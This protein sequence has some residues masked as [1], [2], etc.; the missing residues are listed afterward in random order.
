MDPGAVIPS[1]YQLDGP[2]TSKHAFIGRSEAMQRVFSWL[3]GS[4]GNALVIEGQRHVGKTSLLHEVRR[5]WGA[6]DRAVQFSLEQY[7]VAPDLTAVLHDLGREIMRATPQMPYGI[8]SRRSSPEHV[9]RQLID[10]LNM[11]GKRRTTRQPLVVMLDGLSIPGVGRPSTPAA[12]SVRYFA[13]IM[14]QCP[15]TRFVVTLARDPDPAQMAAP[16]LRQAQRMKI[17]YFSRAEVAEVCRLSERT[18]LA[19]R[20]EW[21]DDAVDALVVMTD[22][23]PWLTQAICAGVW[24]QRKL[25]GAWHAV[26]HHDLEGLEGP[27]QIPAPAG[28]ALR[29]L[30]T[31]LG[32][33]ARAVVWLVAHEGCGATVDELQAVIR[34]RPRGQSDLRQAYKALCDLGLLAAAGAGVR[35]APALLGVWVSQQQASPPDDPAR[36]TAAA[37]EPFKPRRR[38]LTLGGAG[39]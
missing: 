36:L 3:D 27:D 39:A 17:G 32:S 10:L 23:H 13:M 16:V 34:R 11:I 18:G 20:L 12:A 14:Q 35:C 1:P 30:W 29:Q 33:G 28:D 21:T 7:G 25:A 6:Q 22:G 26:S 5:R 9:A 2:I 38:T 37:L 15:R 24:Q 4:E 31:E 19:Q 8:E